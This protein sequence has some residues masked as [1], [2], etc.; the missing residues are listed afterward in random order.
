[1]MKMTMLGL[2]LASVAATAGAGAT[3]PD[4]I[5]ALTVPD[6]Q[7]VYLHCEREAATRLLGFGEAALCSSVAETLRAKAF[8][9]SAERLFEWFRAA[10]AAEPM[11]LS[12]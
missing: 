6:L 8:G 7:R 9:G 4:G 2:A 12:R 5:E 1:M 3:P 10:R 11:A